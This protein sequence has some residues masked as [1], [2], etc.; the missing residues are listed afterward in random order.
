MSIAAFG[1]ATLSSGVLSA[2]AETRVLKFYHLHTHEKV[3]I[4]Y[5]K[6]GRYLPDGLKKINWELRDWRQSQPIK[7][8]PRLL[9]LIW[10]AYRQSGSR[11][12]INVVCGYRAP[13]T[14]SMLRSRS[15]GVAKESQHMLGRALDFFIPGVPLKTMREIGLKMQVGGVGYYPRSG[16]PFVHFDVG[17]ARHWPRMNRREL[18]AVFPNGNTVHVPSDGKPLPG[19]AEA[20]A[21][22]KK[23]KGDSSI[24]VAN[25]G[26]PSAAGKR[27]GG[28]KTLFAALFGGGGADEEED[29]ADVEVAQ[30]APAPVARKI[31][32]PAPKLQEEKPQEDMVVA[33]I[34]PAARPK[35]L[36]AGVP[37]P[38][39]DTFDMSAPTPPAGFP[40]G[41]KEETAPAG[42]EVAALAMSRIPLP[43]RAPQRTTPASVVPIPSEA[44]ATAEADDDV[45]TLVASLASSP[46]AREIANGAAGQLAYSVPMPRN[47]P[48][49]ASILKDQAPVEA[50]PSQASVDEIRGIVESDREMAQAASAPAAALAASAAARSKLAPAMLAAAF[51]SERPAAPAPEARQPSSAL[52]AAIAHPSQRPAAEPR[53]SRPDLLLA[54]FPAPQKPRPAAARWDVPAGKTGRFSRKSSEPRLEAALP[55]PVRQSGIRPMEVASLVADP[56]TRSEI[57]AMRK[58][59]A[60]LLVREVPTAVFTAGFARS[61]VNGSSDHFFG[62]A[63][64]FL[65]VAKFD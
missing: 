17:N 12:Y 6:D 44:V 61:S 50:S 34:V 55:S 45:S 16:S 4:A 18:L 57:L 25:A 32:R 26:A 5:K 39:R 62:S 21:S 13:A 23:R 19:Y 56:N 60:G 7:M 63:I 48:P 37:L 36:Q 15:S 47:R 31:D 20:L 52:M 1:L 49:F 54:S 58:P 40:A 10:E 8:D 46:E 59:N 29:I 51:P 22:Y 28:G 33:S 35:L 14:N 24:A 2:Q 42:T 11:D 64:N 38:I 9:D 41:F 3:S 65:P 27:T 43:R 30:K 53:K